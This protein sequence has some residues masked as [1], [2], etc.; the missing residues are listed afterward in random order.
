MAKVFQSDEGAVSSPHA[1][2]HTMAFVAAGV[3]IT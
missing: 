2:R 1:L 3:G